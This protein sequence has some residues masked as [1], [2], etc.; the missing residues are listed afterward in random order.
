MA[1]VTYTNTEI[2]RFWLNIL[3]DN[4]LIVLNALS[5]SDQENVLQ[6]KSLAD[7]L[8]ALEAHANQNPTA[9]QTAQINREAFQA[10]QDLRTSLLHILD[11][12][13]T[14]KYWVAL[15]PAVINHFI[16]EAEK[17]LSFL[18][19]F[20]ENRKLNFDPL[21]EEIFW[22]RIFSVQNRYIAD[23][24]GYFQVINKESAR[25]FA[26]ILTNYQAFSDVLYGLSRTGTEDFPMAR[27]HHV[28]V[29]ELLNSYYDFLNN[30][31]IL[32]QQ[33]KLPSSMSLLYLDR[34]RRL[35][36][37]F[38]KNIAL[39]LDT[40]APDCDPYSKRISLF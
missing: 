23:N 35:L 4:A 15:K 10:V 7:R 12:L 32:D 5:P 37:C 29:F 26:T 39:F 13:L 14:S 18:D 21:L 34:S 11:L 6:I 19:A 28:A 22:L 3:A 1:A 17:Y 38:L 33:R 9:D 2:N 36:C 27:E 8:D 25:K 24:I 30:L 16:D 31:I 40:K 20:K